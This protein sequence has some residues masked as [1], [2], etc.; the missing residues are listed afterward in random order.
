MSTLN[1]YQ[2]LEAI[3]GVDDTLVTESLGFFCGGIEGGTLL[4]APTSKRPRRLL[5]RIAA[6]GLVAAMLC[7]AVTVVPLLGGPNLWQGFYGVIA[8][9]FSPDETES[10][11]NVT[12]P[13]EEAED[14]AEESEEGTRK[15]NTVVDP[16]DYFGG[17][18][19]QDPPKT[20]TPNIP[21]T[22]N[23]SP[24]LPGF[25]WDHD[26]PNTPPGPTTTPGPGPVRNP[27]LGG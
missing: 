12:E 27:N 14:T 3:G 9:L 20:P 10:E 26:L 18:V 24:N 19:V 21:S 13:D 16:D 25:N 17:G 1:A 2:L 4:P 15:E 22:P 6:A 7:G 11:E 8:P 5:A 23:P